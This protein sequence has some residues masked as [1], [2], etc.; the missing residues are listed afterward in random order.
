[1]KLA[2]EIIDIF[3]GAEAAEQAESVRARL[4]ERP[5]GRHA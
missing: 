3:H 1:M 5:A 2:R 4:S